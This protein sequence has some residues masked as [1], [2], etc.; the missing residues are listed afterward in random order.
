MQPQ[1]WYGEIK[2]D[3]GRL[4]GGVRAL[5]N[6]VV[7]LEARFDAHLNRH[8]NPGNEHRVRQIASVSGRYGGTAMV[9]Y[10]LI[11]VLRAWMGM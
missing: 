2:A 10:V 8:E 9:V 4:E 7:R 11:E 6:D 5:A 1:E 3:I